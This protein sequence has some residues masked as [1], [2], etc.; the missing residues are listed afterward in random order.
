MKTALRKIVCLLAATLAAA[1]LLAG[2]IQSSGSYSLT[3]YS[4]D[5]G[6]GYWEMHYEYFNGYKQ[7][8]M[9]VSEEPHTIKVDIGTASGSLSL[10]IS[11]EN[12]TYYEERGIPTSSFEVDFSGEES[13]TIRVEAEDHSGAF[14]ITW[15]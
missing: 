9:G 8:R 7:K 11:G 2:C 13:I 5:S 6:D 1:L 4:E 12:G 14:I 10:I 15:D 3:N